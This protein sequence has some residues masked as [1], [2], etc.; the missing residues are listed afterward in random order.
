MSPTPSSTD[1]RQ[2]SCPDPQCPRRH[3]LAEMAERLVWD[4][5]AF[6]NEAEAKA[7]APECRR[8]ALRQ[9]LAR[10][11]VGKEIYDLYY[12]WRDSTETS[13]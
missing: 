9:V 7:V 6:A 13:E 1:V 2:Y 8:E 11:W 10:V 3:I 12:D 4:H 5:L